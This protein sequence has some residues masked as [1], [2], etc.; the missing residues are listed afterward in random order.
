MMEFTFASGSALGC[1]EKVM[2]EVTCAWDA[3]GEMG[4]YR[5]DDHYPASPDG[6]AVTDWFEGFV[7]TG[8]TGTRQA[9]YIGAFASCTVK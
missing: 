4:R 7:L 1:E 6:D 3:N 2:V 8:A 9:G 5:A